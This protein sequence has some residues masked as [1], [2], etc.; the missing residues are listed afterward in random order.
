MRLIDER[1]AEAYLRDTARVEP[2]ERLQIRQLTGGVSNMVL[3][4]ERPDRP[5]FVIKQAR[6]KLR[7]REEWLSSV[8]RNWREADVL[9]ICRELLARRTPVEDTLPPASTPRIVFKDRDNYL[10]AMTAAPRPHMVWKESLLAG[11]VDPSVAAACGRLLGTLHAESWGDESI[12]ARLGD[13][14]LFEE[15][16]VDPYYRTLAR[17]RPET[18]AWIERLV[19][20]IEPC[21]L[22]HADFSPKN[23]LVAPAGLLMVDFE[24]GHYG[25]PAFDL[26]FFLTHLMLK[27]CLKAP[28]HAPYVT[29]GETFRRAYDDQLR[30]RIGPAEL[31]DLWARGVQHFAGCAWARLDGKSP[32]D[33]LTDDSRRAAV[34]GLCHD[35]FSRQVSTWSD[36]VGLAAGRFGALNG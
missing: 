11:N 8:E 27:A 7:T 6:A 35:I 21:A 18:S 22:V 34:R 23:L 15:L 26:G 19:A 10:F 2:G 31:A 3:L 4:V 32:V 1:N 33:Y 36:V 13:R 25:D 12:A 9:A 17:K 24:T 28:H 29:L 14:T 30:E 20:S 5:D 16:R